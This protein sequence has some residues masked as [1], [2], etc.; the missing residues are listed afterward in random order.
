MKKL[1]IHL[2]LPKTATSTLQQNVLQTL[3]DSNKVNFLGK[4]L[5]VSDKTGKVTIF[6][7]SGKYIRDAIEEKIPFED[8]VKK[9]EAELHDD[10]LNIFSD[11]GLMVAYPG[12]DNL[13]LNRKL[14]NLKKLIAPYKTE[15]VITL[16][17]PID[18]FYSLYVQLYPD[19]YS[20]IKSLNTVEKCI[21]KFLKEPDNILF[22]SFL[23]NNYLPYL[24]SNFDL[25]VTHFEDIKNNP[26]KYYMAW[27]G[28]LNVSP[29][30]FQTLFE[31]KHVNEKKKTAQGSQKVVSLNFIESKARNLLIKAKPVFV[32]IK[33]IYNFTGLKKLFNRRVYISSVHKKPSGEALRQLKLLFESTEK[34]V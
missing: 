7:Y 23:F 28:L 2:G 15:V 26:E 10:K 1:L 13:P 32:F 31:K 24:K 8:A 25:K 12:A 27:S 19:F 6:N 9:L 18:Y 34:N 17:E 33:L 3:H 11:E 21:N 20:K 16:R 30:N 5:E 22:E 29:E 14:A 4:N